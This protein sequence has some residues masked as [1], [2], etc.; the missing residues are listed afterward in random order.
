DEDKEFIVERR[1]VGTEGFHFASETLTEGEFFFNQ[2]DLLQKP[3]LN[4]EDVDT[5]Y[6]SSSGQRT[7]YPQ[8]NDD[9]YLIDTAGKREVKN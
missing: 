6:L 3:M 9:S 2:I 7:D 1:K 5:Y 8:T 4:E